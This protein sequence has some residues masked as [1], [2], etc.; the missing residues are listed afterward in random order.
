VAAKNKE[1]KKESKTN[2]NSRKTNE[3]ML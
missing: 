3:K 1:Q 2:E